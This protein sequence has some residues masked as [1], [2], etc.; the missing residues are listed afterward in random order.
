MKNYSKKEIKERAVAAFKA[1][2]EADKLLATSDGQF[3][4]VQNKN[5]A[6]LNA[7]IK[8]KPGEPLK[9][10]EVEREDLKASKTGQSSGSEEQDFSKMTVSQVVSAVKEIEDVEI[11]EAALEVVD[12]KGGKEAIAKRIEELSAE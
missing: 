7:R 4:L 6:E 1:N 11:L 12:S 8:G 10:Y 2:P 3:F 9:I 5:A